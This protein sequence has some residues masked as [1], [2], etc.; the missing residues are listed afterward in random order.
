LLGN[1]GHH[2]GGLADQVAHSSWL[3]QGP[4][5]VVDLQGW[6]RDNG[7]Q[8]TGHG[9]GLQFLDE[10]GRESLALWEGRGPGTGLVQDIGESGQLGLHDTH[11]RGLQVGSCL[12]VHVSAETDSAGLQELGSNNLDAVSVGQHGQRLGGNS[13]LICV[14]PEALNHGCNHG[15]LGLDGDSF[16]GDGGTG[17]HIDQDIVNSDLHADRDWDHGDLSD[18]GQ[19][20]DQLS[21]LRNC[22]C[23]DGNR[24][25]SGLVH[26]QHVLAVVQR[27]VQSLVVKGG[28][29]GGLNFARRWNHVASQ[30]SGHGVAQA[31]QDGQREDTFGETIE[32]DVVY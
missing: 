13:D 11:L 16:S 20:P 32:T 17:G 5:F 2:G 4:D 9:L 18:S 29:E 31:V 3:E 10:W 27:K 1:A 26:E 14:V 23:D 12:A 8:G 19:N 22:S 24:H 15:F 21:L 7:F 25:F 30:H 6:S 28:E